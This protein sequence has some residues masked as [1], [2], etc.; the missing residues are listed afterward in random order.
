M[1]G[2]GFSCRT[3][4]S[5]AGPS[6]VSPLDLQLF[7]LIGQI[8]TLS[9][10]AA[11]GHLQDLVTEPVQPWDALICSSSAGKD[12]VEQVLDARE[13][14]LQWRTGASA[15]LLRGQRPNLPV[16]PLPLP[17]DSFEPCGLNQLQARQQ[18]GIAP[19][20]AVVLWLGRLLPADQSRSLAHLCSFGAGGASVATPTW[21]SLSADR[22]TSPPPCRFGEPPPASSICSFCTTW[23]GSSGV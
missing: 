16:I 1:P 22:M 5:V 10:P 18:L 21:C 15:A 14:Q 6:G 11:L 12:A 13:E 3:P 8:H 2:V 19:D 20:A 23:W 7:S 4:R 9:T 17:P